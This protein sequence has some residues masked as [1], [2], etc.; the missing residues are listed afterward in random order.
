MSGIKN[1]S[2]I[3]SFFLILFSLFQFNCDA[4]KFITANLG[5]SGASDSTAIFGRI[6]RQ[7]NRQPIDHARVQLSFHIAYSDSNG[8]FELPVLY[9]DDY[10]R[11]L[12]P[13]IVI[14]SNNF[15][16]YSGPIQVLPIPKEANFELVWLPPVIRNT[17]LVIEEDSPPG[18]NE[19]GPKIVQAIITDYQGVNTIKKIEARF[20]V[21]GVPFYW[22]LYL[23]Q[24]TSEYTGQFESPKL[25]TVVDKPKEE[26]IYFITVTDEDGNYFESSYSHYDSAPDSPIF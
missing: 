8:Y 25:F 7:D 22:P 19:N 1:T 2:I 4:D 12:D 15:A 10:N 5:K 23:V 6:L 13:L 26:I 3:L 17:A 24:A 9:L 20:L 14:N 16:V 18:H 21:D 11:N